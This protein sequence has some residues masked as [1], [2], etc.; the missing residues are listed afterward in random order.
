MVV[1]YAQPAPFLYPATDVQNYFKIQIHWFMSSH[2]SPEKILEKMAE[3]ADSVAS[4]L[5]VKLVA[6][7]FSQQGRRR[8][9]L[10]TIYRP[11]ANISLADCENFSR[12]LDTVL[13]SSSQSKGEPVIEG[14]YVL[15][16]QSPGIDRELKT[17]REFNV[18]EGQQVH[19]QTRD[20]I[21][22]IGNNFV[23]TLIGSPSGQLKLA[24]L[25]PFENPF[26][27]N[28]NKQK[29]QKKKKQEVCED[30]PAKR[31]ELIL[32][33]KRVLHVKLHPESPKVAHE[34]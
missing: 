32:D 1:G 17:E 12:Q 23:G 13:E 34:K 28:G 26:G 30:N 10:V 2:K 5:G 24:N 15:E 33:V 9:I 19:V 18:F 14:P 31:S 25:K 3:I 20:V 27:N 11:G 8:C 22:G 4:P 7:N 21:S 16:V 29:H 6:V